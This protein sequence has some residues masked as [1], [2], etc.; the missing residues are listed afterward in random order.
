VTERQTDIQTDKRIDGPGADTFVAIGGN[1]N[2]FSDAPS[3]LNGE[4]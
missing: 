4:N 3:K 2:T 1:A